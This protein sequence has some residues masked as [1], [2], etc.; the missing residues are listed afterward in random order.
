MQ[1]IVSLTERGTLTLPA[2][3]RK[4]LGVTGGQQFIVYTTPDGEL[5]LRPAVT[6][7]VEIYSEARI[8]E[9]AKDDAAL[10][11]MLAKRAKAAKK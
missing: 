4:A 5:I 8:T 2:H 11:K 6:V 7:P 3:I 10:G 1:D 9:F